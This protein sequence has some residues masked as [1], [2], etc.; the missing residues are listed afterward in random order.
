MVAGLASRRGMDRF[1]PNPQMSH[2]YPPHRRSRRQGLQRRTA[3][4]G[5]ISQRELDF[6]DEGRIN[7]EAGHRRRITERTERQP[8]SCAMTSR[9]RE[10]LGRAQSTLSFAVGSLARRAVCP[11][12]L[13]S[14]G[15]F[16]SKLPLSHGC[17]A[18]RSLVSGL[19]VIASSHGQ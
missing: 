4:T 3:F 11:D 13:L 10:G 5:R 19:E 14:V 18:T 7:R 6:G 1:R 12:R 15:S 16:H 2:R 8:W 9:N 17:R